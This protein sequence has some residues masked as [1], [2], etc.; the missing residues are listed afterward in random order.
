MIII[1]QSLSTH[2]AFNFFI[3]PRTDPTLGLC[4]QRKE[5]TPTPCPIDEKQA[6]NLLS[7]RYIRCH[8]RAMLWAWFYNCALALTYILYVPY[9]ALY[10][11]AL[12]EG[13]GP[14]MKILKSRV[15]CSRCYAALIVLVSGHQN[16][17][18]ITPIS[19]PAVYSK[20]YVKRKTTHKAQ[21]VHVNE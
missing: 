18:I 4:S 20:K 10:G 7:W 19:A 9:R 15:G 13:Y 17:A 14:L 5:H 16:V 6:V 8:L 21:C 11:R 1:H 2:L 12:I 3:G